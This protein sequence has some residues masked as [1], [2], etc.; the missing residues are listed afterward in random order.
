M[1]IRA[2]NLTALT[3]DRHVF[4]NDHVRGTSSLELAA[5]EVKNDEPVAFD[6]PTSLASMLR[7]Y[8]EQLAPRTIGHRPK[9]PFV[10]V[11]GSPK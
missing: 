8:R 7:H 4:L 3:F 2:Q 1:P 6:I 10:N 5:D 9:R 11:D